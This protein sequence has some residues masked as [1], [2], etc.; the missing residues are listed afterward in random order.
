MAVLRDFHK[1]MSHIDF[2]VI[3]QAWLSSPFS[4][5]FVIYFF[6][7]CQDC[8]KETKSLCSNPHLIIIWTHICWMAIKP[9]QGWSHH[10]LGSDEETRNVRVWEDNTLQATLEWRSQDSFA[11]NRMDCP[12]AWNF[13]RGWKLLGS[14]YWD[15]SFISVIP[16]EEMDNDTYNL[17]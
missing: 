16:S 7:L 3:A 17:H 1:E 10:I 13:A 6:G 15:L 8:V 5:P 9:N 11:Y 4:R 2:L 14:W 12:I